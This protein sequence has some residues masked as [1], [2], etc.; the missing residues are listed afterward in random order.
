MLRDAATGG[1]IALAAGALAVLAWRGRLAPRPAALGLVALLAADLLRAGAGLNP[2]TSADF[3][4]PSPEVARHHDTWRKAGRVFTCDPGSSAAYATGR[5]TRLDHERWTFAVLRDT[6]VPAFNVSAE[7]PSALSPDLT[8]LV[9]PERLIDV[10]DA[11]CASIDRLLAP[12]RVAGVAHVISLDPL[13][14][15]DLVPQSEE[16]PR[17]LTPVTVRAYALRDPMPMTAFAGAAG[18]VA[19]RIHEPGHI[20]V[21]VSAPASGSAMVRE[22]YAAG[23]KATVDGR[24]TEVLRA[25]GR[26][27]AFDVPAGTHRVVLDY[28]PPG[29]RLGALVGLSASL[30]TIGLLAWPRRRRN[31]ETT[32]APQAPR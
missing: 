13:D 24:A 19:V 3:F 11:G 20:E 9:P 18:T 26:H 10:A 28:D 25:D 8:M 22:A 27:I 1:A 7:V 30:V 14:H 23:W 31:E 6:L 4:R 16:H 21:D 29:F 2:G 32:P 5:A 15:P 17:A 12:L